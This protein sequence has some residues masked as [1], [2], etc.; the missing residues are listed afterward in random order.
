MHPEY[1][2]ADNAMGFISEDG[3][4]KYNLCHCTDPANLRAPAVTEFRFFIFS[5]E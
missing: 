2:A 1:V 5:L 4:K 3:G